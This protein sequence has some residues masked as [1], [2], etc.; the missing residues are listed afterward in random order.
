MK[1]IVD[2]V[3]M[4]GH[5]TQNLVLIR[6]KML[7][8]SDSSEN[9][10]LAKFF[11]YANSCLNGQ[12]LEDTLKRPNESICRHS[13]LRQTT[14]I[15]QLYKSSMKLQKQQANQKTH[16]WSQ[17]H[18]TTPKVHSTWAELKKQSSRKN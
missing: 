12:E 6:K 10:D 15:L 3:K 17:G 14:R 1:L 11:E 8:S 5:A 13:N 16:D 7:L 4:S 9:K 18:S 2:C